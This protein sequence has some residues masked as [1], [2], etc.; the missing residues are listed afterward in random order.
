MKIV[1]KGGGGA[2]SYI[3]IVQIIKGLHS[4][5]EFKF[6]NTA[7]MQTENMTTQP[8]TFTAFAHEICSRERLL[9]HLSILQEIFFMSSMILIWKL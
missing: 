5:L 3:C 6:I 2:L 9:S 8:M 7:K 1:K 4:A